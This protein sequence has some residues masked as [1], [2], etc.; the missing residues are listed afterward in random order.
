MQAT[1]YTIPANAVIRIDEWLN[2][3]D[4]ELQD[5]C[6]QSIFHTLLIFRIA[7]E[8][9]CYLPVGTLKGYL[10]S[11]NPSPLTILNLN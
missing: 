3:G 6:N 2:G 5:V 8:H 11:E 9:A 10:G 1:S 7:V 4:G